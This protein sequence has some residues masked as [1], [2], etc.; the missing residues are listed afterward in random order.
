VNRRESSGLDDAR[1]Q[2]VD[3]ARRERDLG[4]RKQSLERSALFGER[5]HSLTPQSRL[6]GNQGVS[7]L[8]QE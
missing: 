6:K 1:R 2:R 4:G 7:I 8:R 3:G 5:C